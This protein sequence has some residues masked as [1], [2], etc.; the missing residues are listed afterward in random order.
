M[1]AFKYGSGDLN[2][3]LSSIA[4]FPGG[5]TSL[6]IFRKCSPESRDLLEGYAWVRK[7]RFKVPP[8]FPSLIVL[9]GTELTE[10]I[11]I[12]PNALVLR[13]R[14]CRGSNSVALNSIS[15]S[16]AFLFWRRWLG[17]VQG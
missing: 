1:L 3:P 2:L 4:S 7:P 11:I 17:F 12:R 16:W 6:K 8:S 10:S 13:N 15:P 5:N 9:P 14:Y